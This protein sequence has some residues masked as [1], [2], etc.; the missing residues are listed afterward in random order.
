MSSDVCSS[1]T[2]PN[3]KGLRQLRL[4]NNWVSSH[5]DGGCSSVS[6][7]A[8]PRHTTQFRKQLWVRPVVWLLP[9]NRSGVDDTGLSPNKKIITPFSSTEED[10]KTPARFQPTRFCFGSHLSPLYALAKW[11]QGAFIV[12]ASPSTVGCQSILPHL[13]TRQTYRCM[14]NQP[15]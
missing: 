12:L 1:S 13:S 14:R 2:N 7:Y 8:H 4:R 9:S 3:S 6:R 10:T 11:W 5:N 15:R